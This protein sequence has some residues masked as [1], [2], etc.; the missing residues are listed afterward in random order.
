[1]PYTVVVSYFLLCNVFFLFREEFRP[2]ATRGSILY[3]VITELSLVNC[4][5]SVSLAMF[6]ILFN[7]SIDR[8]AHSDM[9][10]GRIRNIIEFATFHLYK[11]I[12]RGMSHPF[13]DVLVLSSHS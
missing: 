9:T 2:V 5:Y 4:M 8:A 3:F 6:L 10:A 7:Q 13:R 11:F 1:M 12:Q